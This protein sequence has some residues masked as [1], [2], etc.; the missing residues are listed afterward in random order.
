MSCGKIKP[1]SQADCGH[2]FSRR[3]LS[4][5]FDEDNAHA[6]CSY[7]NRFDSSHLD[8]YRD[9]LINKIGRSRFEMLK[10]KSQQTGKF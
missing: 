1:I 10:V 8:G 5:R 3:L 4:V 2:Y 9:N 6:E 7:C